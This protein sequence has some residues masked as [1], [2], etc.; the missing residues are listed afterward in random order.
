VPDSRIEIR[1][2][3]SCYAQGL[4]GLKWRKMLAVQAFLAG[5]CKS[6]DID[7]ASMAKLLTR[8][9]PAID[10][11]KGNGPHR[12]NLPLSCVKT[13]PSSKSHKPH[14]VNRVCRGTFDFW[15]Q[16]NKRHQSSIGF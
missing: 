7:P 12:C 5:A 15:V 9:V 10:T 3:D 6:E 13:A 11:K 16:L 2:F 4:K 1:D 14:Y 8:L